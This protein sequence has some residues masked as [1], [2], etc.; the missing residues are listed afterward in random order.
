MQPSGSSSSESTLPN[1]RA[2]LSVLTF[3]TA[4]THPRSPSP[5][6][7]QPDDSPIDRDVYTLLPRS[8]PGLTRHPDLWFK[9]GSV[10]LRAEN[11]LFRVHISQLSRHSAFFRDLFSLPQPRIQSSISNCVDVDEGLQMEGCPVIVLHDS[12]QDVENL[13][14]ALYDGPCVSSPLPPTSTNT[15][16][17]N[18]G[19]NDPRDFIATSGILRLS[20]KYLI[21]SLRS[22]A[23]AHVSLAWPLDLK[24]WDAREDVA[25]YDFDHEYG[26]NTSQRYPSPI[27]GLPPFPCEGIRTDS[28][29]YE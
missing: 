3:E 4:L 14:T 10:V 7:T 9:D 12:A 24:A 23:L 21:D 20:T 22:K 1:L 11:T 27:V 26:I 15:L 18:F 5:I 16:H 29:D 6:A 28:I 8:N 19:S 17:R 2:K 13:L 25:R